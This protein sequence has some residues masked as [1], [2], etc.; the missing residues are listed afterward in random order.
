MLR[1]TGV[2]GCVK[3]GRFFCAG[4]AIGIG[5]GIFA[6]GQER[7]LQVGTTSI[8]LADNPVADQKAIITV[9][10]ARFTVLTPE[11]VRMEWSVPECSKIMRLL[12]F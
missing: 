8:P 7:R 10:H 12:Y 11:L 5:F 1:M 6:Q 2:R 3:L 9:R 4:L